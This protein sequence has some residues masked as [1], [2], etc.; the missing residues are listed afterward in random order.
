MAAATFRLTLALPVVLTGP[1]ALLT[2]APAS[3][4]Q[5][6]GPWLHQTEYH[7]FKEFQPSELIDLTAST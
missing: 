5:G 7:D 6:V 4:R 1:P 2:L 3:M